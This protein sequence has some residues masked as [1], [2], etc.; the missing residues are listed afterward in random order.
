MNSITSEFSIE[1]QKSETTFLEVVEKID[2]LF[3]TNLELVEP[4]IN[5]SWEFYNN[6]FEPVTLVPSP[7]K[8]N[9]VIENL[10]LIHI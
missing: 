3:N 5:G 7:N 4:K 1:K 6:S 9:P 8:Y 10:S 2:E